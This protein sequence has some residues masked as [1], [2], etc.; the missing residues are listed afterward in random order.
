[1]NNQNQT[2][3]SI[4]LGKERTGQ[5]RQFNAP[6]FNSGPHF[7]KVSEINLFGNI[8]LTC[9]KHNWRQLFQANH[10]LL[11]EGPFNK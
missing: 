6:V 2:I 7:R 8:F 3:A 10:V 11:V 5:L 4:S 9:Q 1:M